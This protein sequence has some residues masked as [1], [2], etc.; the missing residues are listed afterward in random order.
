MKTCQNCKT[1]FNPVRETDSQRFCS[2][3]CQMASWAKKNRISLA[4]LTDDQ[5]KAVVALV[6]SLRQRKEARAEAQA[7]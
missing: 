2:E 1:S 4:G 5:K 7:V 6:A 3:A